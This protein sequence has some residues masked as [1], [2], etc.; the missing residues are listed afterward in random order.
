MSALLLAALVLMAPA[1][2]AE[3]KLVPEKDDWRSMQMEATAIRGEIEVHSGDLSDAGKGFSASLGQSTEIDAAQ[4]DVMGLDL[5][6]SAE[7]E[8]R[9]GQF[10]AARRHLE[11]LTSRYPDS[12]WARKG[13][14]L[15]ESLP[16]APEPS[17]DDQPAA[18]VGPQERPSSFLSR[19]RAALDAG[20]SDEALRAAIDFI[21]RYPKHRVAPEARLLAGALYLRDGQA[22][23][24]VPL[25]RAAANTATDAATREKALYLLGGALLAAGNPAAVLHEV[26]SHGAGHWLGLARIWRAAA[27]DELGRSKD[28]AALYDRAVADGEDSPLKPFARAALAAQAARTGKPEKAVSLLRQASDEAARWR[29]DDL[30]AAARLSEGHV[31]YGLRRF[32]EAAAAYAAFVRARPDDPSR[33][34]A[35][36][37]EGLA[38]KRAGKRRQAVTAF[39]RLVDDNPDSVYA[40]DAHLQLGQLYGQLGEDSLAVSHY[41]R[42]AA[43]S[44]AKDAGAES[45]L[46]VAQVHYNAR[47]YAQ[48]IP[49]YERFLN[50]HPNDK[51]AHEVEELL[52]T[53]YWLGDRANP[54]LAEVIERYPDHPIV[55]RIR[56]GLAVDAYKS[57]DYARAAALFGA[58]AGDARFAKRAD[59]LFYEAE[60]RR[61]MDDD[62]GA[63]AAYQALLARFPRYSRASDASYALAFARLKLGDRQGAAAAFETFLKRSPSS[64][65]ASACWFE[66]A[67]LREAMKLPAADDYEKVSPSDPHRAAALFAAARLRERARRTQDAIRTYERLRA[68]G[69]AAAPERLRG[70]VRLGMLYELAGKRLQA[71]PVY[72]DVMRNAPRGSPDFEAARRRV[73]LLTAVSER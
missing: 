1:L 14:E 18:P 41:E 58:F 36:Y 24:A 37:Q 32:E 73:E 46:L 7:L 35:L 68:A 51:R 25:L 53:S 21:G 52:L 8:M 34:L 49:Y 27:F 17:D 47:R 55:A 45:D 22:G 20:D 31:L 39:Q 40:P 61:A 28:A 72:A 2:R 63:A 19:V 69:P 62:A 33:T 42:M 4:R 66:L 67:Q 12:A 16:D 71:L 9:N 57:K 5:L 54:R 23:Q 60:A 13:R 59:A 38:L 6:R 11:I 64:R 26:P 30:A 70:L 44:P 15:L 50:D 43:V 56:W 48:A 3:D 65:K 10:D 29:L